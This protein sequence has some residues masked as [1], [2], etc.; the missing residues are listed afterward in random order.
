MFI[1]ELKNN[2]F[3]T[4]VFDSF[5]IIIFQWRVYIIILPAL[6]VFRRIP[7]EYQREATNI[8]HQNYFYIHHR[9]KI[10]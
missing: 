2:I 4:H 7:L 1:H 8:T 9:T 5:I 6:L 10:V 3:I